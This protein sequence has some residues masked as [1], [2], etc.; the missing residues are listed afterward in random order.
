MKRKSSDLALLA[1]LSVFVW[2]AS[3]ASAQAPLVGAIRWDAWIG[4][5]DITHVGAWSVGQQV[6][7][8]L[9]PAQFHD[10][11]PF[12]GKETGLDSVQAREVSQDVMDKEIHYAHDY[13]IA[14][15][16]FDWYPEGTG[17]DVARHLYLSSKIKHLVKFCFM[18]QNNF[19]VKDLP[20]LVNTFFKDPD[21]L[22]VLGNR[23]VIYLFG[24]KYSPQDFESLRLQ[25]RAAGLGDPY[26]VQAALGNGG[27]ASSTGYHFD[28]ISHYVIGG[29]H[30]GPFTQ[31]INNSEAQW[32]IDKTSGLNVA[33]CVTAGNDY[34][35]RMVN[36]VSWTKYSPAWWAQEP[37]PDELG[38]LLKKALQWIDANHGVDPAKLVLIYAWNEFDEGGWICPTL[39]FGP[40]RLTAIRKVLDAYGVNASPVN[41]HVFRVADFGAT[42]NTDT[43]SGPAIRKAIAAAIVCG[44]PADVVLDNGIYKVGSVSDAEW[45]HKSG[46]VIQGATDLDFMGSGKTTL[47]FTDPWAGGIDIKECGRIVA[48]SLTIDYDPV[49]Q[50]LSKIVAID[51]DHKFIEVEAAPSDRDMMSFSEPHFLKPDINAFTWVYKAMP[52]GGPMWGEEGVSLKLDG[53]TGPNRWKLALPAK[54]LA[55]HRN[56]L[57]V[58]G[59]RVGDELLSSTFGYQGSAFTMAGNKHAEAHDITL[60]AAPD[61]AFVPVSNDYALFDGCVIKVKAGSHRGLSAN[62]DGI[63]GINNRH[64]EIENCSFSGLGDD[65]INI[66]AAAM[67][68]LKSLSATSLLFNRLTWT[69]WPLPPRAGDTI[70]QV[71]T[72]TGVIVGRYVVKSVDDTQKDGIHIEFAQPVP[73]VVFGL[74]SPADQFFNASEANNDCVI[75]NNYFGVH[76]G[77]DLLLQAIGG[78]V[79][80]NEFND[81]R[82]I[83]KPSSMSS[84]PG[85]NDAMMWLMGTSIEVAYYPGW[86]EGPIGEGITIRDNTFNGCEFRSPAIWLHDSLRTHATMGSHKDFTIEG[87]TFKNR[88]ASAVVAQFVTNVVVKNNKVVGKGVSM[89]ATP[90]DPAFDLRQC[91]SPIATGNLVDANLFTKDVAE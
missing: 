26:V 13:G 53:N 86:G 21:Y 20:I 2:A 15:W 42:P 29:N 43:D 87:N 1:A 14:Y 47:I 18:M 66:H 90:A 89:G 67:R 73:D 30:G 23:P 41:R 61:L 60:L 33:P 63:H 54:A 51:P 76:R 44:Q 77:R 10:R 91:A 45:W 62:A 35:P 5:Y 6:E 31:V 84:D 81:Q 27:A 83:L 46:I 37:T 48:Q 71:R 40:D 57:E 11:I 16:A 22:K 68:P 64:I 52:D 24:I 82:T 74:D 72:E 88:N 55:S 34:R 38:T 39:K 78:L 19:P 59:L 12:Y 79:E 28:A 25:T 17:M 56:G 75:R 69:R 3:G 7:K 85:F 9:G 4:D 65:G 80:H 58:C 70:E 36:P 8:A 50:V 49:P 32:N